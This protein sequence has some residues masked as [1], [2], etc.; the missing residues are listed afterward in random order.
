MRTTLQLDED[1]LAA[2][3]ALAEQQ[4]R[5]LGEVVSELARKGLAPA[6]APQFRNGIRLMPVRLDAKPMTLEQINALRDDA[7]WSP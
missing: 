4:G 5:T 7:P 2:A 6:A 3:R 1:V